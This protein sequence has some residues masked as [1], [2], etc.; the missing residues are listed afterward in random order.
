MECTCFKGKDVSK[1]GDF[2]VFCN[3]E[4][5]HL[6]KTK[7]CLS[8]QLNC[9]KPASYTRCLCTLNLQKGHAEDDQFNVF[10]NNCNKS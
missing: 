10:S 1:G 2:R 3:C 7:N 9:H 5:E 4:G 8:V 6:I